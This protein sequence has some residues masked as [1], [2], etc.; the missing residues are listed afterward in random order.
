MASMD[1]GYPLVLAED[2]RARWPDMPLGS[3]ATAQVLLEDA[4]AL[5]RASAPHWA[6]LDEYVLRM[7]ACAMVKRGMAASAYP[8][9]ASSIS[10]TAGPYNQQVSFSNP[11]GAL[12]L[13]KA[14]KK[15]LKVGSQKAFVYDLL[16]E[17]VVH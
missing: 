6:E 8:D 14:E 15:L 7:V 10:Q 11:N 17:E 16:D 1:N 4:G 9:G 12:F 5:I 2:L 3:D 13:T